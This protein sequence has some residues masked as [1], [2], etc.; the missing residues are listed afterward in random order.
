MTT[1]STSFHPQSSNRTPAIFASATKYHWWYLLIFALSQL[2]LFSTAEA[3][4]ITLDNSNSQAFA[5]DPT[6]HFLITA[7]GIGA[8]TK[9]LSVI[10]T[11]TNTVVGTYSFSGSGFT[12]ELAASGTQAFWADQGD[13]KVRVI[14][15]SAAG[16][17]T[18][19]RLDSFTF[20]TGIASLATTY[21]VTSQGGGDA[22]R[23]VR[24]SDGVVLHTTVLGFTGSAVD[25]DP[26]TNNYYA[27]NG[28]STSAVFDS[29]GTFLRNVSGQV[30]GVDA[31]GHYIYLGLGTR[32][33]TQLNSLD[34]SATG[35]LFD[36]GAG[37]S[38]SGAAV[39][40]ATGNVWV[41][42]TAQNVVKEFSSN[43]TFIQQFAA[44]SPDTIAFDNGN[45]Y[46]HQGGT[47]GILV[48]PEPSAAGLIIGL[49][50]IVFM[51]RLRRA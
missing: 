43:L 29:N 50:A 13:G 21:G 40:P 18:E 31:A 11:L 22:L 41:T 10:S 2:A 14:N 3:L 48:V 26:F 28:T 37:A 5:L 30:A 45:A 39:D 36:F 15:I 8:G 42:L 20:P 9:H 34:D 47:N 23:I 46:I 19:F 27:A 33:M 16:V 49:G 44:T 12:A 51:R 24:F 35:K 25:S 7:E 4:T 38:I 1:T 32:T 17:P 6:R